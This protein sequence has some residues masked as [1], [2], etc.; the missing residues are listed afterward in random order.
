MKFRKIILFV[1][2][3]LS[4]NTGR[5][6]LANVLNLA[7]NTGKYIAI[8]VF[9]TPDINNPL[10]SACLASHFI[11]MSVYASNHN[12]TSIVKK[13]NIRTFPS[14]VILNSGGQLLLPV[15]KITCR[16]DIEDYAAMAVT[17]N[18]ETKPLAQMDLDYYNNSMNSLH[19]YEYIDRRTAFGLDNSRMIDD[20]VQ[21]ASKQD[22][23][24]RKTLTLFIEKNN[25]NIPGEFFSF[26]QQNRENVESILTL[27]DMNFQFFINKSLDYNL[28]NICA[29]RDEIALQKIIDTK[30]QLFADDP[31]IVYN[32]YTTR[33]YY[34][35]SQPVKLLE[36]SRVFVDILLQNR[37]NDENKPLLSLSHVPYAMH[38]R[39]S[40]QYILETMSHKNILNE[41]LKWTA[42]AEQMAAGNKHDIYETRAC[43]LYKLGK[44]EDAIACMEK[45]FFAVPDDNSIRRTNIGLLLVKMKRKERIY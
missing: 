4:I 36:Q 7:K 2:L 14:I 35:T 43:L 1:G 23:L 42:I 19:L 3:I 33:Y 18:T 16:N 8:K 30:I 45:A 24:N 6:E 10:D 26:V 28:E 11:E 5:A 38:L 31:D 13:Y 34:A 20:Y 39:N 12:E 15:K 40:A 29:N 17:I 25:I 22:L 32:E 37:E 44:S 41:A 9:E 27:N 21:L